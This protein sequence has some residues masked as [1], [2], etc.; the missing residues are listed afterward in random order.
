MVPGGKA[1]GKLRTNVPVE[2]EAKLSVYW[3]RLKG[4]VWVEGT[5]RVALVGPSTRYR[6]FENEMGSLLPSLVVPMVPAV[7]VKFSDPLI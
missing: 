7:K 2:A 6:K 5:I 4:I 3:G 1:L